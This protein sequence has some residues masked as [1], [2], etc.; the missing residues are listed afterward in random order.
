MM[1]IMVMTIMVLDG[2]GSLS[3]VTAANVV[4]LSATPSPSFKQLDFKQQRGPQASVVAD[5]IGR[6]VSRFTLLVSVDV[7]LAFTEQR[8]ILPPHDFKLCRTLT[9][10]YP[11]VSYPR[12]L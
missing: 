4:P 10:S 8:A 7:S 9:L 6:H 11:S 5:V 3:V 1:M 12:R 2:R